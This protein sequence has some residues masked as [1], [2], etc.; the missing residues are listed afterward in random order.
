MPEHADWRDLAKE[1]YREAHAELIERQG[2]IQPD[3]ATFFVEELREA[4]LDLKQCVIQDRIGDAADCINEVV[5]LLAEL[6]RR[7]QGE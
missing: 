1:V 6:R 3:D 5:L 4:L 7:S 2:A